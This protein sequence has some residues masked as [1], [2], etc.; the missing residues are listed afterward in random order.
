MC[1]NRPGL[2]PPFPP[3]RTEEGDGL[4]S[5]LILSLLPRLSPADALSIR[6][7]FEKLSG[8]RAQRRS[9]RV[10]SPVINITF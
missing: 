5:R 10:K 9:D 7:T 3:T 4:V 8:G 6:T 2:L 1:E